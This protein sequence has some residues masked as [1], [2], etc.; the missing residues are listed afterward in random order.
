MKYL[1]AGL[2]FALVYQT[3]LV[4]VLMWRVTDRPP[5]SV[6]DLLEP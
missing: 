5:A 1:L 6:A 3:T 2:A 4:D